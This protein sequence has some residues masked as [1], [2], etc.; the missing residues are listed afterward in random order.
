MRSRVAEEVREAQRREM[1]ALPVEERIEL[2]RRLSEEGIA[3]LMASQ[4]I[5]RDEAIRRIHES[6]SRGRRR[7][8]ANE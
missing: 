7:S 6:H 5:D 2:A 3:L 4:G 8:V 1:L